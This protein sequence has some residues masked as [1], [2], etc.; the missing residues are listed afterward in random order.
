ML[1]MNMGSNGHHGETWIYA[2][3]R[4]GKLARVSLELLSKGADLSGK[5]G[6]GLVAVLVGSGVEN[7][8]P[9]LCH[10]GRTRSMS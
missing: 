10:M 1:G 6:S 7:L 5:L 8:A 4:R 3:Q 9:E 2:E